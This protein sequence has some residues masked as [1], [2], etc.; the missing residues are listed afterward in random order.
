MPRRTT[1]LYLPGSTSEPESWWTEQAKWERKSIEN[2]GGTVTNQDIIYD[3]LHPRIET[4]Y[5]LKE[6]E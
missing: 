6:A 4:D 1:V 5:N 2:R 3:G